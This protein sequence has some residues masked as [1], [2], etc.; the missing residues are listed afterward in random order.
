MAC[1]TSFVFGSAED[2]LN[3][4][5]LD[6][7]DAEE[8]QM[9]VNVKAYLEEPAVEAKEAAHAL[10]MDEAAQTQLEWEQERDEARA[11]YV[12]DGTLT[13]EI[14]SRMAARV[15]IMGTDPEFPCYLVAGV[16][17]DTFVGGGSFYTLA[18]AVGALEDKV[19]AYR[20]KTTGKQW[21][22]CERT[23]DAYGKSIYTYTFKDMDGYVE[24]VEELDDRWMDDDLYLGASYAPY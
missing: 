19:V 5:A 11:T 12:S 23:V 13:K 6:Q 16:V 10:K 1:N 4:L 21:G 18:E 15:H 9:W 8:A 20:K 17:E 2:N 22:P 14:A 7:L 3:A 24:I